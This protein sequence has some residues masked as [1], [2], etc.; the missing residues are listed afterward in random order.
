METITKRVPFIYTNILVV[1]PFTSMGSHNSFYLPTVME[2]ETRELFLSTYTSVLCLQSQIYLMYKLHIFIQHHGD[3]DEPVYP[4]SLVCGFCKN[5]FLRGWNLPLKEEKTTSKCPIMSGYL[6]SITSNCVILAYDF[7]QVCCLT[8]IGL[9]IEL[10]KYFYTNK[11]LLFRPRCPYA[12]IKLT[13]KIK[14]AKYN[15]GS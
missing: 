3:T 13:F 2:I 15:N 1:Q 4:H 7:V 14:Q 6:I 10:N 9:A 5:G 12:S 8:F 11:K